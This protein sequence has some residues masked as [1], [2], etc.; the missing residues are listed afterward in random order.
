M[1]NSNDKSMDNPLKSK[2]LLYINKIKKNNSQNIVYRNNNYNRS[3]SARNI[4]ERKNISFQFNN[5]YNTF[6]EIIKSTRYNRLNNFK[7]ENIYKNIKNK[8][9]LNKLISSTKNK[10]AFNSYGNILRNNNHKK[11]QSNNNNNKVNSVEH[12]QALSNTKNNKPIR[13]NNFLKAR[14]GNGKNK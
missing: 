14:R 9:S 1:S 2:L 3:N 11:H 4:I 7:K 12:R 5:N 13:N 6:Y 8:I 10:S